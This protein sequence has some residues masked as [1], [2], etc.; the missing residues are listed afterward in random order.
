MST[1]QSRFWW[2]LLP[3]PAE[4]PLPPELAIPDPKPPPSRFWT[5]STQVTSDNADLAMPPTK[6]PDDTAVKNSTVE[7]S[8]FWALMFGLGAQEDK[9]PSENTEATNM[10]DG[11]SWWS[12]WPFFLTVADD[13]ES[14]VGDS[15]TA[16]LFRS[17]KFAVETSRDSC[18]YAIYC[19]YGTQDVELAVAGTKT[20]AQAVKYNH[21]KRPLTSSEVMENALVKQK[22]AELPPCNDTNGENTTSIVNKT[23]ELNKKLDSQL[24]L[25]TISDLG[26]NPTPLPA[27]KPDNASSSLRR[28]EHHGASVFPKFDSNF[29][30]ITVTTKM[31]LVGEAFLHG[32]N[33]SEKHL[34]KSTDRQV[35]AKKRKRIKKV[36]V[37][38][39]H[40]FLPAKFVKSLIGQ[41]TGN[42]V[43]FASKALAAIER[44][45]SS[46]EDVTCDIDTIALEGQGTIKNR[47]NKS[48]KLLQ[49]WKHE[50]NSA[51]FVFVVANSIASPVAIKLVSQMLESPHFDQL[52]GKKVGLL[53]IAGTIFGPFYNTDTK[54]V[55]RAYTQAENE[56][57]S[58]MLEL[59]R[60]KSALSK[61]L[62]Q[63]IGHLCSCNVKV[64]MVGAVNDQFVP[65]YS[66]IGNQIR[67]PNLFKCMYVEGSSDTPPFMV[68]LMSMALTMINV[69]YGD[70][71]LVR[72]LSDRLQG[73][74]TMMGSHGSVFYENEVYDVAVRFA[75]ETTSL[76]YHSPAR[77]ERLAPITAEADKNLYNLPWNVRGLV[78][79]LVKIKHILNM[80]LLR[81]IVEEYIRWEPT[82]R[83]WR[84]VRYCFAALE[85]IT[86]DDLLL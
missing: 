38:S 11:A 12:G 73:G 67:H 85:D 10:Q 32:S 5:W 2:L 82:T 16:E 50:I 77:C 48:L 72:D 20:E 76:V 51:D 70:Q 31:R 78:N 33:T 39:I 49:N 57:I 8:S 35:S 44:W 54:I 75:L 65:L 3:P 18:H 59:Q 63:C 62:V 34:Y 80:E 40:S 42:A 24:K 79:D 27:T 7:T 6:G 22:K 47:V 17:A 74:V 21:K 61:D 25:P 66:A 14:D 52:R 83:S 30:T 64:T 71:N 4:D 9:P 13:P 86:V 58:E 46:N 84:E 36:V 81:N 19:K 56:V 26:C 55:I 29:R 37:I 43:S 1:S 15:A 28:K 53:S 60:P 68:Q 23:G 45:I 41:S 69:G